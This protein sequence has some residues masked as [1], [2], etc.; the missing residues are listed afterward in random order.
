MSAYNPATVVARATA[1]EWIGLAVLSLSLLLLSLDITVLMLALPHITADVGAS[2]VQMLWIQDVYG[3]MVAGL[4]VTMGTVGDR[5]GRRRLLLIG[6]ACFGAVSV[7]AA[8]STSPEMLIA[9]RALLGV[10]GATLGPSCMALIRNLFVDAKQR[11]LAIAIMMTCFMGGAAL[12]PVVGGILLEFFWWGSVFLLGVPVM[13][14]TLTLGPILLPEYRDPNPGRLDLTS[15]VMSLAAMLPI[16]YGFKELAK[17]GFAWSP[18]TALAVGVGFAVLFVRRQ[19]RIDSPL[20]DLRLFKDRSFTSALVALTV[21]QVI[22]GGVLFLLA[23]YIQLVQGMSPLQAGLWMLPATCALA[24]VSLVVPKLA[25]RFPR[26]RVIAV[27]LLFAAA[28]LGCFA[29]LNVDSSSALLVAGMVLT[30]G[31]MAPLMVLALDLIIGSAPEAKAGSAAALGETGGELGIVL[32]VAAFGTAGAVVYRAQL[33]GALPSSLSE[34]ATAA[35]RESLVEATA[36]AEGLSAGLAS[37]ILATVQPAFVAGLNLVSL[38]SA[39]LVLGG[40]VAAAV[41]MRGIGVESPHPQPR[42]DDAEAMTAPK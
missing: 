17:D 25:V 32:G 37:Q 20:L 11:T 3:F 24:V 30:Y 27:G 2:A 34:S 12:G 33:D 5:I 41:L 35:A 31:G 9:A 18:V 36:A 10:A 28:G 23:Q 16:V 1:R 39:V 26:E 19:H 21:I 8:Y 6:A 22:S 42:D 4:L 14:L 29:G 40:A 7:L 13:L 15:V 38:V